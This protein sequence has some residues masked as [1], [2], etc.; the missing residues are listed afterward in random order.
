VP[1]SVPD[2][3]A[4]APVTQLLGLQALTNVSSTSTSTADTLCSTRG[5]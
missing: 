3:Q 1:A 5:N 4:Q 2:V